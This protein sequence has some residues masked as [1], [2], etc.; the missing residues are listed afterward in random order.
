[1]SSET[2]AP[3]LG[4]GRPTKRRAGAD[5]GGQAVADS[6]PPWV[7]GRV[8]G[9]RCDTCGYPSAQTGLPWCPSCHRGAMPQEAFGPGGVVWSSARVRL[10]VLHRRAPYT[11]AYV[12]LDDGPRILARLAAPVILPPGVRVEIIDSIDGDLIADVDAPQRQKE[13]S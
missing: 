8:V 12:D 9:S 2:V 1:M 11:L 3:S 7:D 5:A 13:P 6:R 4:E 10:R